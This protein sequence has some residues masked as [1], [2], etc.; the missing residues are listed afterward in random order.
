[1]LNLEFKAYGKASQYSAVDEAL[2]TA[3][4]VQNKW[5]RYWMDNKGTSNYDLNSIALCWLKSSRLPMNSIQWHVKLVQKELGL[6]S[7]GYM[8]TARSNYLEQ[9][10]QGKW[11]R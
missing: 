2:K 4:F 10:C 6:P 1:M 11:F 9:S 7:L 5:L 8:R 3:K